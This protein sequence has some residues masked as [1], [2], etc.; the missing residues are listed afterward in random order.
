MVYFFSKKSQ[1]EIFGIALLF[2][3]II[4]GILVYGKI[5][6]L[7]PHN[8]ANIQQENKYKVLA[9]GTLGSIL[10]M[11]TGCDVERNRDEIVDLID[12]CIENSR[13]AYSDPSIKCENGSI[14]NSCSYAL[15]LIN[16]SLFGFLNTSVLGPIPFKMSINLDSDRK[17]ILN[18]NFTN[19]GQFK[20]GNKI[21]VETN[22]TNDK[23]KISYLDAGYNRA[24]SGIR[25]WATAKRNINFELFLYYR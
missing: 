4:I 20:Y 23:N 10:K 21:L 18:T 7:H 14:V 5:E 24:P 19:F 25:A 1:G 8:D 13:E 6:A 16:E 22:P 11:S 15:K 2:V 9:E 17:S 3:I 12:Y